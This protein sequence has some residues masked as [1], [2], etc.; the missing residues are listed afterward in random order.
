[1]SYA[2][3]RFSPIEY[4][5]LWYVLGPSGYLSGTSGRPLA[6]KTRSEAHTVSQ[7]HNEALAN[8]IDFNQ[9]R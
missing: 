7:A 2:P 6:Y 9:W 1:M 4:K 8:P 5:G 3:H